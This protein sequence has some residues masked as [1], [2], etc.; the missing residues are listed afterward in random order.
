MKV[1]CT[2]T[3][4]VVKGRFFAKL[5][6]DGG[7]GPAGMYWK[8]GEGGGSGTQNRV[9]QQR[10]DVPYGKFRFFPLWVALRTAPARC[11]HRR[12]RGARI[13]L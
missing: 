13:I 2:F 7:K 3:W 10:P 4:P 1:Y 8:R 9:Y 5:M 12:R 11:R 6:D